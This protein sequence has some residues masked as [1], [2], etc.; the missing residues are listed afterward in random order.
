MQI[1][2]ANGAL[3]MLEASAALVLTTDADAP[4]LRLDRGHMTYLDSGG[5]A[6]IHT[7]RTP[8]ATL[9]VEPGTPARRA[10]FTQVAVTPEKCVAIS[11]DAVRAT[12]RRTHS[13][14]RER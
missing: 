2:L 3:V 13:A 7:T 14:W 11:H 6:S 10:S 8:H 1:K 12:E 4:S 5:S 9:S